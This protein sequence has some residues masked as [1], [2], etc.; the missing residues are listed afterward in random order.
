MVNQDSNLGMLDSKIKFL[1][2]HVAMSEV[3]V[4]GNIM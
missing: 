2:H 4:S 1:L 3:K